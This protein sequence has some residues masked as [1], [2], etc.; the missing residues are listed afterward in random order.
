MQNIKV[1]AFDCDGVLFDTRKTNAAYYNRI[2]NHMGKPELSS[3]Q[4]GYVHMHTVDESLAFLFTDRAEYEAAQI[5]RKSMSY[6]SFIKNMI[7]EDTLMLLLSKLY[8]KYGMSIVTNRTDT[9]PE[10]METFGLNKYFD[11]VVTA[12]DVPRPK[13]YPDPLLKVLNFY[14]IAPEEVLYIGDSSVDELS[15]KAA[16]TYFAAYRNP[17]LSADYHIS[18]LI[19][20]EHILGNTNPAG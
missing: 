20:I 1:V 15:A 12:L 6:R 7:M 19:E 2:L 9:M 8:E 11:I 13:P 5:F 4:F 14:R 17:D 18:R 16:K 3:D 10:V